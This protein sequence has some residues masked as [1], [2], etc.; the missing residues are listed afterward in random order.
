MGLWG[1]PLLWLLVVMLLS[2]IALRQGG[3]EVGRR[4]C[5]GFGGCLVLPRSGAIPTRATLCGL[6]GE[7]PGVLGGWTLPHSRW[8]TRIPS[9]STLL[10]C[11]NVPAFPHYTWVYTHGFFNATLK[12]VATNPLPYSKKQL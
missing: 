1:T 3:R 2:S 7:T 10:L 5:R 8:P 6:F 9:N 11:F 12:Q 4:H